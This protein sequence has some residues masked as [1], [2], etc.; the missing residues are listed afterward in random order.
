M[1]DRMG[2]EGFGLQIFDEIL[3]KEFEEKLK[4]KI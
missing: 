1:L 2:S 3:M 4:V